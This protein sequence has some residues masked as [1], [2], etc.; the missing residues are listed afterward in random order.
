MLI[1]QCPFCGCL[2]DHSDPDFCYPVNREKTLWQAGCIENK[3]GCTA[4]V[5]GT[6]RKDAI[7]KWNKRVNT[8]DSN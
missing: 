5:L 1:K 2:P 6:T 7:T 8:M 3:G 4:S